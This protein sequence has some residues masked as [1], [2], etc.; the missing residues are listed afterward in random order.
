MEI[1]IRCAVHTSK[2]DSALWFG[3]AKLTAVHPVRRSCDE[4]GEDDAQTYFN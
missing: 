1:R 4:L 2:R 3:R